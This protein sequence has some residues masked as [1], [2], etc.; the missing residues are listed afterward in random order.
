MQRFFLEK[1]CFINKDVHF[2]ERVSYQLN[3][4]L[5]LRS[6][7]QVIALDNQG[8]EYTVELIRVNSQEATG[9]I[10]EERSINTEPPVSIRLFLSLCQRDK[11]EWMLQKCT[12]IGAASFVPVISERSL[13]QEKIS[14][15]K[16]MLRW[17][18]IIRE[19]AEQSGRGRIPDLLNV[20]H[21]RDT[22]I[23]FQ[24]EAS[25][26]IIAWEKE[27]SNKLF[28]VLSSTYSA[29]F[30]NGAKTKEEF[31]DVMIGPEGGFSDME[32]DMLIRDGY[33]PI[34]LGNR[35][36]RMETAAI[37]ITSLIL[38]EIEMKN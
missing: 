3:R 25:L 10:L 35:I 2:P 29:Q 26:K 6:G 27:K 14:V 19:A 17:R 33:T 34:T 30:L 18:D 15:E 20:H 31:I 5:R 7:M 22:S 16:K 1:N 37:V 38:Y 36:L 21:I 12:E 9:K 32:I 23:F 11:F 28:D 4:V 13:V 8:M 24:P